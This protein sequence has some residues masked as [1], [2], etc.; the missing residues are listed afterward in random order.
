MID[1]LI[2]F[3]DDVEDFIYQMPRAHPR[4]KHKDI[5]VCNRM[6]PIPL[7]SE[8]DK[9]SGLRYPYEKTKRYYKKCLELGDDYKKNER[10]L[11]WLKYEHERIGEET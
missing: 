6:T 4:F 11:E 2:T 3:S 10:A 5:E 9:Q 1:G 8:R 7:L